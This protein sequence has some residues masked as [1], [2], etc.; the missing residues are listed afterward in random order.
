MSK[1]AFSSSSSS[2]SSVSLGGAGKSMESKV[3]SM[4]PVPQG[5]TE[6]QIADIKEAFRKAGIQ[7]E[8]FETRPGAYTF[9]FSVKVHEV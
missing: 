7:F 6:E 2:S 8:C 4:V 5:L 1:G 9:S 3:S